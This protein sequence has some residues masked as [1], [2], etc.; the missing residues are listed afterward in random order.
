MSINTLCKGDKCLKKE[1][2]LRFIS[3]PTEMQSYF[4]VPPFVDTLNKNNK[5][6][7]ECEYFIRKKEM[8]TKVKRKK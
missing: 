5:I 6:I 1:R 7:T 4:E 3:Y 2:C 8:V